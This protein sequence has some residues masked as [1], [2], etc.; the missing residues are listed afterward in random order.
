MTVL[1]YLNDVKEGGETAFPY[2]N[3]DTINHTVS[4][5]IVVCSNMNEKRV[6]LLLY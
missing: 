3:K 1:F 4:T 6:Y 2:A 5:A